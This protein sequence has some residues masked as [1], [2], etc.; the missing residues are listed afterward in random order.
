MLILPRCTRTACKGKT[1][2]P[3]EWVG[4]S[5]GVAE[6]MHSVRPAADTLS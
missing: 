5:R 2:L 4:E 3:G 1:F 6:T